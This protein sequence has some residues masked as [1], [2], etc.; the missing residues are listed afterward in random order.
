MLLSAFTLPCLWERA[1]P[2]VMS[3]LAITPA[4]FSEKQKV[5]PL[6]VIFM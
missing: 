3:F 4:V 5:K 1:S 6:F 2:A